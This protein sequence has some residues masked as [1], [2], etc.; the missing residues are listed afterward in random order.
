[1]YAIPQEPYIKSGHPNHTQ[2]QL[3]LYSII[4]RNTSIIHIINYS[5]L[6]VIRPRCYCRHG[7][8]TSDCAF[9][10]KN[11]WP[12][13]LFIPLLV[14]I[15]KG[16][17]P[18]LAENGQNIQKLTQEKFSKQFLFLVWSLIKNLCYSIGATHKKWP[19][20]NSFRKVRYGVF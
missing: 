7:S 14:Q 13:R 12:R 16:N 2:Q 3:S 8:Y 10:I 4:M 6:Q 17:S 9:Y 1:M 20:E 19:S 18:F 11:P 5:S 15:N